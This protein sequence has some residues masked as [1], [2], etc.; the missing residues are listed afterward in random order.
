MYDIRT[1]FSNSFIPMTPSATW[2][3][4][5]KISCFDKKT[6][7]WKVAIMKVATIL[8]HVSKYLVV[9]DLFGTDNLEGSNL[10]PYENQSVS[11]LVKQNPE[12]QRINKR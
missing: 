11:V 10:C 12:A 6:I 3:T 1:H 7:A 9:F 8:H 5:H 4:C 2:N